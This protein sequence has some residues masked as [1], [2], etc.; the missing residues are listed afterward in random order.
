MHYA[1]AVF[2]YHAKYRKQ[3]EN[4]NRSSILRLIFKIVK[5]CWKLYVIQPDVINIYVIM[6]VQKSDYLHVW[7][8]P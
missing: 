8:E 6:S 1:K 5:Y 7:V 4:D 2:Q 3:Y